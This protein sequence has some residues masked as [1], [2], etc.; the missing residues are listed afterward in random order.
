MQDYKKSL[1]TV[2]KML[3]SIA[4]VLFLLFIILN[5]VFLAFHFSFMYIDWLLSILK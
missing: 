3:Y 4:Y 2:L 1:Q 5:G